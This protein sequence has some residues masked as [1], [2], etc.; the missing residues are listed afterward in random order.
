VIDKPK[1]DRVAITGLGVVS[2]LGNSPLQLW[3]RLVDGESGI[4]A[5]SERAV[6]AF[7]AAGIAR[8]FS[9]AIDDFGPLDSARKRAIRKGLKLMC[10]EIQMGVAAAQ[11]ALHDS[12]LAP[13][14]MEPT[15]SGVVFGC[16]HIVTIPQEFSDA[17]SACTQEESFHFEHWGTQGI[18]EVA[19]LWL[20][21]YLPNMPASH[22]AI[23][24]DLRGPNNSITYRE[25]SSNLAI[26]EA[27]ETILR[28]GADRVLAGATG[29]SL[30][31]LRSI[32][33]SLVTQYAQ[34]GVA[35]KSLS[36]P[37]DIS[38][39]GMVAAE[40]AGAVLLEEYT[41][42][43]TRGATIYGEILGHGSSM[44]VDQNSV[45]DIR[46]AVANALRAAL[47]RAAIS[48]SDV[49]HVHAHGAATTAGDPAEAQGIA[50]VFGTDVPVTSLKG[51]CGNLGAAGGVVELVASLLA[52][53]QG[54]LFP[55]LN[56]EHP[57]PNCP[58]ALATKAG[59]DPGAIVANVNYTPHG[60]ASAVVARGLA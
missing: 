2:P 4:G 44:A 23:Y 36:R 52:I 32:Q 9:G 29:S 48:A 55:I 33:L 24:N 5:Y 28:G 25:A 22:I 10:R 35:P 49:G 31:P 53:R 16:D 12:G 7:S 17:V 47:R 42:A 45:A 3:Q 41:S 58:I 14:N 26:G 11:L 56:C 27:T 19:P 34:N 46:S 1:P 38:R 40:G 18:T 43:E 8:D 50:D 57:D 6:A 59:I 21:K 20:L 60:Q 30:A 37:F 39:S 13:E 51:A 54:A 15:R